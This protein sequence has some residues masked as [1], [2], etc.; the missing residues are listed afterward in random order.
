[1]EWDRNHTATWRHDIFTSNCICFWETIQCTY[2]RLVGKA[3]LWNLEPMSF[4]MK[5]KWVFLAKVLVSPIGAVWR[6]HKL[7]QLPIN[8]H[9]LSSFRHCL[10][11]SF[12]GCLAM[13]WAYKL[14]ITLWQYADVTAGYVLPC[15]LSVPY[16]LALNPE[17]SC[18]NSTQIVLWLS[19]LNLFK[20]IF[21]SNTRITNKSNSDKTVLH[22]GCSL[23]SL[24]A[25]GW[26][27]C[28]ILG[29]KGCVLT[30]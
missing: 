10:T 16:C 29:T 14:T 3:E 26:D 27:N 18:C 22:W 9:N 7:L 4:S 11:P 28:S 6:W 13:P 21:L 19:R 12:W 5:D 20:Q 8:L 24:E 1:M 15:P 25:K 17:A 23:S 2:V 30:L